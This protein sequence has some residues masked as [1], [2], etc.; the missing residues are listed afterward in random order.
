MKHSKNYHFMYNSRNPT[1]STQY[2]LFAFL[3]HQLCHMRVANIIS[4]GSKD[5][6]KG[7]LLQN[8]FW[9]ETHAENKK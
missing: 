7:H 2:V 6:A 3:C 9:W 5:K 8:L 4:Y 1:F